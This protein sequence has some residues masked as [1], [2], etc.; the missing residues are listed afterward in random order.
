MASLEYTIHV[1][2]LEKVKAL[3]DKLQYEN[4]RLKLQLEKVLEAFW[5]ED[6]DTPCPSNVGLNDS[7]E[8]GLSV[9]CPQ[10]WRDALESIGEEVTTK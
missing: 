8:C 6:A 3:V 1:E 7:F 5:T 2:N 10:C 4:A 9:E